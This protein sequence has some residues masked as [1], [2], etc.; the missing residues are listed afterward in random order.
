M[1]R[2][3]FIKSISEEM[4]NVCKDTHLFPSV[5][6]AQACLESNN[7]ASVLSAKHHNYFGMKPGSSWHGPIIVMPTTEYVR[8]KRIDVNQPFRVY[9]T[10]E[11]CF[12]DHI[13]LLETVSVYKNAG[14]FGCVTPEEQCQALLKAGYAT[15]PHYA[16]LLITIINQYNLK[17]FDK[18]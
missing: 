13:K 14:L 1:L 2:Q 12:A 8:G 17:E 15:D 16:A 6:I 18:L 5:M 3:D 10:L 7:G 11:A 9:D 4:V